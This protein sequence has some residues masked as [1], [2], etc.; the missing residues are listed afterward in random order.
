MEKAWGS[1]HLPSQLFQNVTEN[2]VQNEN[3]NTDLVNIL[4]K[5]KIKKMICAV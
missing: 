3:L 1:I 5:F 2:A 4:P